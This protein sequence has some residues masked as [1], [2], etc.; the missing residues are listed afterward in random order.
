MTATLERS[1]DFYA[2]LG[3]RVEA[4]RRE[5][6]DAYR[7]RALVAHPD[8][9]GQVEMMQ[10]LNRIRAVLL[11]PSLRRAYDRWRSWRVGHPD[12]RIEPKFFKVRTYV[13][14]D[15]SRVEEGWVV[16]D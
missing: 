10:D 15:P 7:R 16:I 6:V 11:E 3:V 8:K 5:I 1:R 13:M 12:S 14:I 9:G 4:G 2:L